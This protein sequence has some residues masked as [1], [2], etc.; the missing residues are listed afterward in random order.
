MNVTHEV[1]LQ[2][3][4]LALWAS[5]EPV[6]ESGARLRGGVVVA[7]YARSDL[8]V[9]GRTS[10]KEDSVME[11]LG[12]ST[13]HVSR[14]LSPLSATDLPRG[15]RQHHELASHDTTIAVR[16]ATESSSIRGVTT[17][18]NSSMVLCVQT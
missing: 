2:F 12:K 7:T 17:R 1:G 10:G 6:R 13:A 16:P 3:V 9:V 15:N 8:D 5:A 18:P 11:L 4:Y 14:Q